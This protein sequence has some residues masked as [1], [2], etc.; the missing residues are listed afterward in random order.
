MTIIGVLVIIGG[1]LSV[2]YIVVWILAIRYR[3]REYKSAITAAWANKDACGKVSC[4][5]TVDPNMDIPSVQKQSIDH[6]LALFCINL[7]GSV[8]YGSEPTKLES[9]GSLY[10][11]AVPDDPIGRV[12]KSKANGQTIIWIAFRGT[13]DTT[14][15][16]QDFDTGQDPFSGLMIDAIPKIPDVTRQKKER[17]RPLQSENISASI[18]KYQDVQTTWVQ[19]GNIPLAD[20]SELST[21]SPTPSRDIKIHSGFLKIFNSLSGDMLDI[22]KGV[23]AD[24]IVVSGHSLGAALATLA[25]TY[26]TTRF[27]NFKVVTYSF[28]GPRVGNPA[29]VDLV[30]NTATLYRYVNTNDVIPQTP[31]P[32]VP[33]TSHPNSP[34]YFEH[35]GT[36]FTFRYNA[37]SLINNHLLYAYRRGIEKINKRGL[38]TNQ[39]VV[40]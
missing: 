6:S 22:I 12:W 9:L 11:Y 4:P 16:M 7:I 33:N 10:N 31:P 39:D 21:K 30:E 18:Q 23:K 34:F 19:D 37:L 8:K 26:I 15:A 28:A 38:K 13:A 1:L 29:F 40:K 24:F 17:N 2:A 32:I 20:E 25:G 5:I 35:A 3:I 27:S 36:P 14:E